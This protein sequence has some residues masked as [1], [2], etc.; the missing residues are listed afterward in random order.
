[1]PTP[2]LSR[3]VLRR[4]AFA[5]L[6]V[7]ISDFS[8]VFIL[9]V[10]VRQKITTEQLLQSIAAGVL[11]RA[12]YDGGTATALLGGI[13]HLSIATLWSTLYL[14]LV[15][16]LPALRRGVETL[17]GR[18]G[19]GLAFGVLVWCCMDLIVLPL[20]QA[21]ATPFLSWNFLINSVQHASMIGVPLALWIGTGGIE[22]TE[23]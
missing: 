18:I 22:P 21:R 15:R 9:W 10:L 5:S 4:L 6:T 7:A 8:Y 2:P 13:L 14:L 20:S 16:S 1:M 12:A 3:P 23:P 19:V 11:G 17:S